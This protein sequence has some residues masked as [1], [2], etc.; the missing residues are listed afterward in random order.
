[1]TQVI[2]V[3]ESSLEYW[4]EY[5]LITPCGQLDIVLIIFQFVRRGLE[6]EYL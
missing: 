1:M 6:K 4:N 2:L 3:G 5:G